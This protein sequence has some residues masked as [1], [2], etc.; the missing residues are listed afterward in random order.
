MI[1][2][3]AP[4]SVASALQRVGRAGHVVGAISH[5]DVYPSSGATSPPPSSRS[6]ACSRARSRS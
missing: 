2:V 1:Q 3:S 6:N 4:P 5:G